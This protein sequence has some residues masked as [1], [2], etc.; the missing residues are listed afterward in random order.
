MRTHFVSASCDGEICFPCYQVG[1][2]STPATHKVGEE[3]SHDDPNQNRH[4]LTAYVCCNCFGSI[5]GINS[6]AMWAGC[7]L[8]PVILPREKGKS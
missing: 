1:R 5:V 7:N 3:M 8:P 6:A 2:K 4:N